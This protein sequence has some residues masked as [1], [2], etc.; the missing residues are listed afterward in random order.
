MPENKPDM[1]LKYLFFLLFVFAFSSAIFAQSVVITSKKVTYTRPKPTA[2]FK[3]TFTIRFP[4]VKAATKALSKKIETA[5]SYEKILS[6]NIEEEKNDIQWLEE[7]DYEIGYNKSGILV[8]TLS[9]T[10]SGAYPSTV[11]K[12]VVVNLKTGNRVMPADVFVN[13]KGLAAMAKKSQQAEIKNSLDK[14]KSQLNEEETEIVKEQTDS[15]NFTVKNLDEFSIDDKGATFIYDYGF[16][17]VT[18]ALQPE[19]RFFFSWAELKPYIKRGG[20]LAKF[21]R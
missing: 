12:T 1:K 17:H 18:Q 16:R 8:I 6:L 11:F 10:G 7:A 4:K 5:I 13:L 3:K 21:V 19:G 15:A 2:D 20:L 14:T 9:M